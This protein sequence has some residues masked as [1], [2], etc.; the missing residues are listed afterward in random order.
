[1]MGMLPVK[2]TLVVLIVMVAF[3]LLQRP[4][5][6]IVEL[7]NS[8]VPLVTP[9]ATVIVEPSPSPVVTQKGNIKQSVYPIHE[10]VFATM[11][12]VGEKA[13]GSNDYIP[14]EASAWDVNWMEKFGGI[15]N[16]YERE[17]YYPKEFKPKQNPFYFAL[18]YD[19]FGDNGRKANARRIPW[20][21]SGVSSDYSYVKNRW[22]RITYR[23]QSCYAQWE[24]VGP[25]ETD[26]FEY[27]FA[28]AEPKEERAGIDLSPAVR[29]C[30]R[31]AKND[32]VSWQ[33]VDSKDVPPG[34]WKEI[35]TTSQ[36]DWE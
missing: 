2:I 22:I 1:M 32:E 18:P 13:D 17:G 20:Y 5:P 29:T 12:W 31:M 36:V 14:N 16:P 10:G 3:V 23:N 15:D 33:F 28:Q 34:P 26:D 35:V 19:D 8:P 25:F 4:K 27:V 11:F 6:K 30:L 9:L 7:A 24:D 21:V